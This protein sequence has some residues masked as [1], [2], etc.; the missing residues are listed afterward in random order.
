MLASG[1]SA[2]D[3]EEEEADDD[4]HKDRLVEERDDRVHLLFL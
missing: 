4:S 3:A 1:E 2:N